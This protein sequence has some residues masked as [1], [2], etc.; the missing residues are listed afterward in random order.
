MRLISWNVLRQAG[1]TAEDLAG[2]VDDQQPDLLLLQEATVD[3][4]RVQSLIGGYYWRRSMPNRAHGL[5]FWCPRPF[6]EPTVLPLPFD[7]LS[8]SGDRRIAAV[9]PFGDMSLINVHLAHGQLLVRRQL[10]HIAEG[11]TG[12][13]AIVGDM[14]A[15]GPT[16]LAGF[17]DVGPRK[18]THMAKGILPVRIDRCLTRGI[19]CG[20]AA[21]LA[22]GRSDHHPILLELSGTSE[23]APSSAPASS[24]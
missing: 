24:G 6:P 1:A 9:L 5:A 17:D 2:L 4:D 20:R 21:V 13:V 15:V 10:R 22:R 18:W 14:N 7:P 3:L 12:R 16:S 11:A 8:R 23:P 19:S